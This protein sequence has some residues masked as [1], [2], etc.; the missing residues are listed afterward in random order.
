MTANFTLYAIDGDWLADNPHATF[1]TIDDDALYDF[2]DLEHESLEMVFEGRSDALRFIGTGEF[3]PAGGLAEWDGSDGYMG[4]I[5]AETTAEIA[6]ILSKSSPEEFLR[7]ATWIEEPFRESIA[8]GLKSL[9]PDLK[10]FIEDAAAE[11][12][13][14]AC[15]FV[16]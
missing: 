11:G 15:L 7:A 13:G 16:E 6:R 14:L 8:R 10:Q 3:A 5:S 1:E 4:F 12:H 2:I 9:Y